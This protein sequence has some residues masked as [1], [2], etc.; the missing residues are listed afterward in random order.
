AALLALLYRTL[1]GTPGF[2]EGVRRVL[3]TIDPDALREDLEGEVSGAVSAASEQYY[4]RIFAARLFAALPPEAQDLCVRLALSE[5]PLPLDAVTQITGLDPAAA[6]RGLDACIA[7]GLVQPFSE[8]DLPTL[9]HPPGLL[10]PWLTAL[11]RLAA[12]DAHLVHGQL[13]AFWRSSYEA[14]RET[15]LRVPIDDELFACRAHAQHAGD[16][17]TFRWATVRLAWRLTRR[18]EWRDARELLEPVP[19]ADRDV[20]CLL[21]LADAETSLGDW[22]LARKHLERANKLSPKGTPGKASAWHELATIDVNEGDYPAARQKF[23]KLL[24]IKQAIGDRAGEAT[25][26]HNLATIDLREGDYP[27]ARQKFDKA[28]TMRQAIGDRAGE[29]ATWHQLGAIAHQ[30][31]RGEEAARL[32][33]ISFLIAQAIGLGELKRIVRN[34]STIC[35]QLGYD[36][37]RFDAML[38]E[39]AAAYQGDRGRGL[40]DRAFAAPEEGGA[41]PAPAGG[42]PGERPPGREG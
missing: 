35:G 36:Q 41:P 30:M 18:T 16:G 10:R 17:P 7:F 42:C 1:G 2:L 11:G 39:A 26:W 27:A 20:D 24:K 32:T 5:L 37:G 38:A 3:R 23:D 28:L 33:A 31:G 34:L 25:T 29:V 9:Y 8:P 12:A 19:D 6:A 15:E 40:I 13:A 22:K 21:A 14:D 4:Q